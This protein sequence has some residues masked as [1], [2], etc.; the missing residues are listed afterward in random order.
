MRTA[1]QQKTLARS[2]AVAGRAEIHLHPSR[3]HFFS[4]VCGAMATSAISSTFYSRDVA[5]NHAETSTGADI[6]YGDAAS[7]HDWEFCTRSY[8]A[9]KSGDQLVEAMSK[10]CGRL[11]GDALVVAQEAGFDNLCESI[12][13]RPTWYRTA[14]QLYARNGFSL[15]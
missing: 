8:I 11:R 7:F 1:Q 14:D 6:S 15:N 13:G 12:D 3:S 5:E 10:V 2:R 9:G 4:F